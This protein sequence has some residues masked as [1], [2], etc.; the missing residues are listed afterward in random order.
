MAGPSSSAAATPVVLQPTSE[1]L[2]KSNHSTWRAQVLATLRGARLKGFIT[3]SKKEPAAEIEEKIG[4]EKV[5]I[6]NPEHEDWRAADQ[7]VL[8]F[9]LDSV[10]KEIL[11]RVAMVKTVI[12]AWKILEEQMSSHTRAHAVN[13]RMALATIRKGTSFVAEYLAKMQTL[14]NDMAAAR[15]PFDD[16][17]LVR[18]ILAGL[19]EDYDSIVNSVLARPQAIT[20][21]KLVAQMLAFESRVDLR[22]GGSDHSANFARRGRGG[23]DRGYGCGRSSHGGRTPA[24][25]RGNNS[26]R[27]GRGSVNSEW[28]QCQV[29]L[30]YGHTANKCWHRY[31]EDYV[32]SRGTRLLQQQAPILWT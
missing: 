3:G 8:S 17:D 13:V 18:Y 10:T 9:L 4:N 24:S 15:K 23:F 12:G 21:S 25:G 30:K 20:V 2:G 28:P 16:E 7:Q 11:V 22:S 29:C 6:N 26:G 1:K 14:G 31:D 32:P 5:L 27:G 19:D